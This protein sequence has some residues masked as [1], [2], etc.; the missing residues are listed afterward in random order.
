MLLRSL[1]LAAF[2][3]LFFAVSVH[4]YCENRPVVLGIAGMAAVDIYLLVRRWPPTAW[5]RWA[6]VIGV[7]LCLAVIGFN[8]WFFSWAMRVCAEQ[9]KLH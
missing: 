9:Q 7:L 5:R 1:F 2:A 6:A 8:G 3:F 4:T